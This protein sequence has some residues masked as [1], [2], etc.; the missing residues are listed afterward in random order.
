MGGRGPVHPDARPDRAL[1]TAYARTAV[2]PAVT[3]RA[4]PR[5]LVLRLACRPPFDWPA[6]LAHF[7]A[8]AVEGVERVEG[9]RYT[10][11]VAHDEQVGVI[12]VSPLPFEAGLRIAIAFPVAS[13]LPAI[14]RR[15]RRLFDLDADVSAI[16]AHLTQDPMLAPRVAAHPG[17]RVPGGWDGFEI[18]VRAVLGQQVSV[19]AARL[20]AGALA[21]L[22]ATPLYSEP[23]LEPTPG[24]ALGLS[25]PTAAQVAR[26]DLSRIGMP[27]SR[28]K[29]LRAI[30]VAALDDPR[31]FAPSGTLTE[32]VGRLRAIRG[33]GEWTA[34]YIALRA[35]RNADAF[36][37]SDVGL[38]RAASLATR[39]T[40]GPK[41]LLARAE[42]WRPYRAYAAQYLWTPAP[43]PPS[44]SSGDPTARKPAGI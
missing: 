21:R 42:R 15:L 2:V 34:Q 40:D 18:A 28:R 44:G 6:M 17:L 16:G 11:V 4:A 31:L 23:A 12:D 37:G 19:A 7:R 29:A 10:R 25:F 1:P 9:E 26:A 35:V 8:R 27:E 43:T 36:P 33:V 13:A 5:R 22:C 39:G 24:S 3:P 14:V 30:A 38:L 41:A 20:L 32:T